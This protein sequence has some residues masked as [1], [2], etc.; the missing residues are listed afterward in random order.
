TSFDVSTNGTSWVALGAGTRTA[1]GWQ[2]AG[3]AW[4]ANASLRAR[5]FVTGGYFNGSGWFVETIIGPPAIT[6]QPASQTAIVDGPATFNVGVGG[7][8]PLCYQWNFNGT[9]I[10]GA[11]NASL[12]LANV[13]LSQVG[14]YAVLV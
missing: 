12:M 4:P 1:D 13:Q 14:N 10:A 8:D 2:L 3:L 11:T 7:S 9:N 5:G 6:S